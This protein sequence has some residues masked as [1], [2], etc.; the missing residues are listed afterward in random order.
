M[1]IRTLLAAATTLG[2]A[3]FAA[4]GA[5]AFC[6]PPAIA[7]GTYENVDTMTG[8]VTRAEFDFV[9]EAEYIG[10]PGERNI[11]SSDSPRV[12]NAEVAHYGVRLYGACS[13]SDCDWGTVRGERDGAGRIQAYYNHGFASRTVRVTPAG[14]DRVNLQVTSYYHDG[15]PTQTATHVMALVPG[16][17]HPVFRN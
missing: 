10:D 2:L 1:R 3:A 5:A 6:T 15:R 4:N 9:C 7:G 16:T 17:S 12:A 11:F 14:S 13:P 8:G